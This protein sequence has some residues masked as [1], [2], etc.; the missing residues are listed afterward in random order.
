[1]SLNDALLVLPQ[2]PAAQ[3]R[4]SGVA[5]T[6]RV[7]SLLL[8][9]ILTFDLKPLDEISEGSLAEQLG[10][11]RTPVR[12]ALARLAK[13]QLVDIF[14]QRGTVIA[15]LRVADLKRSQFLRESLELGLLRRALR[16]AD[17]A[18]L[19]GTLRGE[20]AVQRTMA[21]IGDEGRFYGSDE[22]F[23]RC[24][25]SS[26]GLSEIWADISDAKLHMD[27]FRHLMLASVETLPVVVA[28]HE[29]I[30]D[31]IEAGDRA[32]AEEALKIHLRR[33]FAFLPPA[34]AAHPEYFEKGGLA[35]V[36]P[37]WFDD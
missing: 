23:H 8:H 32:G 26:A 12:E 15:P 30:V 11:S 22:L 25:A 18:A 27:R 5:T 24:I 31:A 16:A 10:V 29:R 9:R 28:Q 14:P 6:Q 19:V 21:D 34:F 37:F 1:M 7:F 20:I 33:I 2:V 13:L 3:A 4:R 35:V 36:D 17:R